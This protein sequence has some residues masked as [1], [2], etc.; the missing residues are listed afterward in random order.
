MQFWDPQSQKS[1][2]VRANYFLEIEWVINMESCCMKECVYGWVSE[3]GSCWLKEWVEEWVG[4]ERVFKQVN[5]VVAE[6]DS[7]RVPGGV[8]ERLHDTQKC[9]SESVRKW[10]SL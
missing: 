6:I 5:V 4:D 1:E 3:T 10:V 9:V 8:S 2:I 7:Q